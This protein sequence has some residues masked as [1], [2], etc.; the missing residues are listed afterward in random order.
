MNRAKRL[1]ILLGVLAAAC[2]AAFAVLHLE[3]RCCLTH[4][5]T[6]WARQ[7]HTRCSGA[8]STAA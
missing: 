8:I 2:I 5:H 6:S 1:Y 3:Q 4:T 7:Q